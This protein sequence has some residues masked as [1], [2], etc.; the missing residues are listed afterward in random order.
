MTTYAADET[1]G[2]AWVTAKDPDESRTYQFDLSADLDTGDTI[3]GTPT[4]TATPSGL[5]IGTPIVDSGKV[6][7]QLSAGSAGVQYT[8]KCVAATAG[9][10]T[11]VVRG[12]LR[13]ATR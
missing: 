5:T 12:L 7:V 8:V 13:V 11:I 6:N 9:S 3:S 1:G 2:E 10:D 4:V